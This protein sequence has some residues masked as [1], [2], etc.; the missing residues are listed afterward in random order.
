MHAHGHHDIRGSLRASG[1]ALLLAAMFAIAVGLWIGV[2]LAWLWIGSKV[3]TATDSV[4]AAIAVMLPGTVLTI[5]A[6]VPVLGWMNERYERL[7]EARGLESFG[8]APLEAVLVFSAALAALAFGIWFFF[9][10]GSPPLPIPGD[11]G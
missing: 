7:R 10:S 9:L 2:P 8:Q 11:K 6:L 3:Q 1:G 4:G 5:G